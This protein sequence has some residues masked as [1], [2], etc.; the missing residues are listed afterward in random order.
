[1]KEP[2]FSIIVPAYNAVNYIRKAL[3]SITSQTFK[4]YEL[5]V[6]CDSC[7]DDTESIA[8]EYTNR[9]IHANYHND[10]LARSRGLD[11][12]KGEWVLF[13]DD[14][15]WWLHE[16]VLWQIDDKLKT[17]SPHTDVLCFSFIF[18]GE[19]YATPRG[20][21]GRHWYAVW[22]KCWRRTSIG[23]TR[24]PCVKMISD[25]YFHEAMFSKGLN[26]VEWDMPMYYYNYM[27][28]GSQT[29]PI[30]QGELTKIES[31]TKKN[32]RPANYLI[33]TYPSR[34]WYVEEFLIPSMLEQGITRAQIKV[35]NDT[36]HIGNLRATMKSFSEI[37]MDGEG[38][39]H[40]QDDIV[41]SS[42]FKTMT[43]RYN[44]GLVCGFCSRYS[45]G[46]PEGY[47]NIRNMW[48]SFPCIRIPNNLARECAKWFYHGAIND[49]KYKKWITD[50]KYDDEAFKEFLRLKHPDTKPYNLVPNIV[51]HVDYL[52]GGSLV[53]TQREKI[54]VSLYWDEDNLVEELKKKLEERSDSIDNTR[55]AVCAG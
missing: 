23:N 30:T 31:P 7:D 33:H 40:L 20:N 43:E 21:Y 3:D 24:F 1:M 25:K 48:F 45:E 37:P 26:I 18:K 10:G 54:A 52:L 49:E 17:I 42:N 55:D 6:V 35:W 39:W 36:E 51:N 38:T 41:I 53:N 12:A 27:R 9:V 16:Y 2:R 13:M 46:R 50:R 8:K 28:K 14:D 34:L 15:D 29:N 44:D 19:K 47:T 22:N 4:D 32:T 5:I 11:E